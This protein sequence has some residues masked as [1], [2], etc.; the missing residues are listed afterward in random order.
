MKKSKCASKPYFQNRSKLHDS[1]V[2]REIDLA[3]KIE[4]VRT[5]ALHGGHFWNAAPHGAG[6]ERG[7]AAHGPGCAPNVAEVG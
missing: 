7:H 2:K 4:C 3:S 6:L 1:L 5:C